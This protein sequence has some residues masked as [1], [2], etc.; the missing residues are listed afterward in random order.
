GAVHRSQSRGR[1][2]LRAPQERLRR[3]RDGSRASRRLAAERADLAGRR[4]QAVRLRHRQGGALKGKL[5]YM[6]PEQAWGRT[7]DRRS[8]IFALA[9][10][11]FEMLTFFLMVSAATE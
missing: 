5:Q 8:D 1:A 4:H 9:A 7:I 3:A 11:L 6:S 2:R 10:V